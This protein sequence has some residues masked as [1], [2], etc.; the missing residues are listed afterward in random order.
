MTSQTLQA[1]SSAATSESDFKSKVMNYLCLFR[2]H[3]WHKNGF[4]LLGFFVLGDYDNQDLLIKSILV[5]LAFALASSS[6][7]IFNDYCDRKSDRRH[8]I[9]KKRPL[10]ARTISVAN[11][12]IFAVAF[13][14][15]S[16]FISF[17]ISTLTFI[18]ILAYLGNN[19]VYSLW[20]KNSAIIDIFQ[21]G[22]G[23][24]LRILTG[25]V[26]IGIYISEWM[27]LTGFMVS[28]F[29]G[30]SKRYA[31]LSNNDYSPD[32][33]EVLKKYS[34]EAL[35]TFVIIMATATIMTYALYTLSAH[36]VAI[37]G[38][39]NLIYTIPV[40]IFGIFRYLHLVMNSQSGEDPAD[41]VL[42]DKQLLLAVVAWDLMYGLIILQNHF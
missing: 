42:R 2:I 30:F 3:H 22:F 33:R 19:F 8:R 41:L 12:I 27:V 14:L 6:V 23:F 13:L 5:T 24:M 15:V 16:I 10:A 26:G 18:F 17:Q 7:Y 40:V 28:L 38:H 21:I 1:A 9:K 34:I 29:I 25:T 31:E 36:S 37:H 20:L 39:T 11:G 32:Q 35:R 4:V